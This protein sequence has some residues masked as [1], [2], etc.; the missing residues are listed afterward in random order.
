MQKKNRIIGTI[1]GTVLA[2]SGGGAAAFGLSNEISIDAHGEVSTVRTFDRNVESIL[3]KQGVQIKRIDKVVPSLEENVS[4]GET[5][6]IKKLNVV[7]LVIEGQEPKNF[8]TE[9]ETVGEVVQLA[10]YELDKVKITP[11]ASTV[12]EPGKKKRIEVELPKQITFTGMN[13]ELTVENSYHDT[14][15]S[16]AELYLS[17]VESTDIFEPSRETELK[18]GMTI[19]ITRIRTNERTETETIEFKQVVK[20]DD[21]MFIGEEKITTKGVNGEKKKTIKDTLTDG[22]VTK[23]EVVKEKIT[24]EPVDE[25]LSKGTKEKPAPVVETKEAEPKKDEEKTSESS[26]LSNDSKSNAN[27]SEKNDEPK[28]ASSRSSK[29]SSTPS[30]TSSGNGSGLLAGIPQ[31]KIDRFDQLAQCESGGNWS[32]NTGNSYYGGIQFNL[33]SWKA[34]GGT[35]YAPRPDLATREQ[36]IAAGSVLQSMQ[37]WGA[38]PSCSK[39]YGFI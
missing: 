37:G 22:K 24:K 30:D 15:G 1:A 7:E 19:N 20:E 4:D 38:W 9:Y 8:T 21:T 31:W 29:R 28:K 36:Q 5:I 18:D 17:D 27:K 32:I 6:V 23:T 33:G 16:A 3:D 2:L 34:A 26:N 14:V 35:K 11:F 13:G 12:L 10:G 39:K 25:I